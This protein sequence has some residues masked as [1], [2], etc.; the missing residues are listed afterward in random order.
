MAQNDMKLRSVTFSLG[1][2]QFSP[3]EQIQ[4]EMEELARKREGFF[5]R[6][7]NIEEKSPQSG[8]FREKTVALIEDAQTG[9]L[10]YVDVDLIVFK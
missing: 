9:K 10:H 2:E 5:H 4:D 7:V 1:Y 8:N 6:F 3:S